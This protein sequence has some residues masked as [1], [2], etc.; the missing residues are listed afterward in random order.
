MVIRAKRRKSWSIHARRARPGRDMEK[1]GAKHTPRIGS[2]PK[3]AEVACVAVIVVAADVVGVQTAERVCGVELF[4]R[5]PESR[6]LLESSKISA[7]NRVFGFGRARAGPGKHLD[8]SGNRIGSEN[9]TLWAPHDFNPIDVVGW[10]MR[11]IVNT[12]RLIYRNTVNQNLGVVRFTATQ[13]N[14]RDAARVAC[15]ENSQ[16][17]DISEQIGGGPN[18][19]C[20]DLCAIDNIHART[21]RER[22]SWSARRSDEYRVPNRPDFENDRVQTHRIFNNEIF[23][24]RRECLGQNPQLILPESH[25]AQTEA[26]FLIRLRL[27]ACRPVRTC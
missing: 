18:F 10:N 24:E 26:A 6:S 12:S 3:I 1:S 13:E 15:A 2:K 5:A 7:F 8:N 11:E 20:I 27:E 21:Q 25:I 19:G 16:T 4:P 22:R 14:G 9:S 17:A 23:F